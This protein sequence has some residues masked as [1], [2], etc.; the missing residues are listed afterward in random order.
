[1]ILRKLL[2]LLLYNSIKYA[3]ENME[4]NINNLNGPFTD[5]TLS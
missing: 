1:M 5:T 2:F 3:I 4:K